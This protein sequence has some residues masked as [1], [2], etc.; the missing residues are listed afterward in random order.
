MSVAKSVTTLAAIALATTACSATVAAET[1]ATV[2]PVEAAATTLPTVPVEARI[3]SPP[4]DAPASDAAARDVG[5]VQVSTNTAPSGPTFRPSPS[6]KYTVEIRMI[7]EAVAARMTASWREG[8]PVPLEDLRLLE[9]AHFDF[10]GAVGQGELVVHH[11]VADDVAAVFRTLF[12]VEYPIERM[13]L[14]DVYGGDDTASME[15]NNTSAFNCRTVAGTSKWS[16]HAYGRA[17][18]INPLVNPYVRGGYVSPAAGAPYVDRSVAHMGLITS[19]GEV[20]EAFSSI[21]WEWGGNWSSAKDYQHFS[22]SG[23]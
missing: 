3:V 10:A 1:P 2:A 4:P 21:G 17:I 13:E 22:Q 18:D 8:C 20:V 16:E 15:A 12:A 6:P 5:R 14:V 11:D 23:R 9:I 7:D 19:G